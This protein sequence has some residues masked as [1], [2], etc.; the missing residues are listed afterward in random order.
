MRL[1]TDLNDLFFFEFAACAFGKLHEAILVPKPSMDI[2]DVSYPN[3]YIEMYFGNGYLQTDAVLIETVTTLVPVNWRDVD[4]RVGTDY[5]GAKSAMD[6]GIKDGWSYCIKDNA[7]N[8]TSCFCMTGSYTEG[9]QRTEVILKYIIPFYAQA[10]K[11]VMT[12]HQ[13]SYARLTARE[14]EVLNWLKQGKSS[15][16]ISTILHVSKR[17]IDYHVANIKQKLDAV[18]RAQAVAIAVDRGIIQL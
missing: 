9:N 16:D 12:L 13:S 8:N 15:W 5:P 2:V 6:F 7:T 4:K 18:N 14:I 10:Y 11:R 1:M 17:T 3:G